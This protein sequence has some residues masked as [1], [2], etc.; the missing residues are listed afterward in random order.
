MYR[1]TLSWA[2]KGQLVGLSMQHQHMG[3]HHVQSKGKAQNFPRSQPAHHVASRH[4]VCLARSLLQ[5]C[6]GY[7]RL[8]LCLCLPVVARIDWCGV[9]VRTEEVVPSPRP[10]HR[11][12]TLKCSRKNDFALKVT[13]EPSSMIA[14]VKNLGNRSFPK[15]KE[16]IYFIPYLRLAMQIRRHEHHR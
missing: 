1:R 3:V 7:H 8:C 15:E 4:Q 14:Q 12:G 16:K 11:G 10:R 9:E 13:A 2:C 5:R 6:E